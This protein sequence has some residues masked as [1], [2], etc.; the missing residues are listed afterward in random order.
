MS[1]SDPAR[2]TLDS[3]GPLAVTV[4]ERGAALVDMR[5]RRNGDDTLG[6]LVL[7]PDHSE[8]DREADEARVGV[9]VGRVCGRIRDA[10]YVSASGATVEL[11]ANSDRHHLHG[12]GAGALGRCIWS[13]A[14]YQPHLGRVRLTCQSPHGSE[15]YPGNLSAEAVYQVEGSALTLQ[16]SAVSDRASPINLTAHPYFNLAGSTGP[17]AR[18]QMLQI[19]ARSIYE[20]DGDLVPTGRVAAFDYWTTQR[21][22]S[23]RQLDTVFALPPRAR[24]AARLV[25]PQTQL[26]LQVETDQPALVAYDGAHLPACFRS[27]GGGVCLEPQGLP[28]AAKENGPEQPA[29]LRWS[30]QITYQLSDVI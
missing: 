10:R 7:D 26:A 15:G 30:S 19:N 24:W 4:S 9:I 14:E 18:A 27:A 12:G 1:G 25:S 13:V 16:L 2:Y 17:A 3:S 28:L 21:P 29:G 23:D 20:I 5:W 22:V 11:T 6:N 8:Y